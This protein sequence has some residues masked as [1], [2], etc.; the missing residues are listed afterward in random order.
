MPNTFRTVI[1]IR[2]AKSSW[3]SQGLADFDRPL[4]GRGKKAAPLMGQK[5]RDRGIVLDQMFAS[6]S[7]RTTQTAQ[8]ICKEIAFNFADVEFEKSIYLGGVDDLLDIIQGSQE[9]SKTIAIFAHNP[10]I[11]YLANFLQRDMQIDNVP[12]CGIVSITFALDNWL[13]VGDGKGSLDFF[14]YPKKE[15]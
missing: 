7:E 11:T 8:L 2:H 10:G 1:L 13:Y 6:P 5:L 14:D 4:N 15:N 3:K 9:A 12:T